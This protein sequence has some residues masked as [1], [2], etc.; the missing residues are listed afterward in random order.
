MEKLKQKRWQDKHRSAMLGGD[1]QDAQSD[2]GGLG[3]RQTRESSPMRSYAPSRKG[4]RESSLSRQVPRR[5]Y[6]PT[7]KMTDIRI[8]ST[9]KEDDDEVLEEEQSP[10]QLQVK[11]ASQKAHEKGDDD[12][13][14]QDSLAEEYDLE[15][16]AWPESSTLDLRQSMREL[17]M[18]LS[19]RNL[20]EHRDS[21]DL[22][23]GKRQGSRDSLKSSDTLKSRE[24]L[25]SKDSLT[26]DFSASSDPDLMSSLPHQDSPHGSSL[27]FP[28]AFT[29]PGPES[30]DYPSSSMPE[31]L[32]LHSDAPTLTPDRDLEHQ[33]SPERDL[34][35]SLRLPRVSTIDEDDGADSDDTKPED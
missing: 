14:R 29:E 32:S 12:L 28:P 20:L 35:G 23:A 24:S 13:L 3:G 5:G 33:S 18:R 25:K 1:G 26:K 4:S 9:S 6:K 2:D 17:S 15:S 34:P 31:R 8:L 11:L 7:T 16:Q 30:Q 10:Y 21:K 19:S 27:S 22:S